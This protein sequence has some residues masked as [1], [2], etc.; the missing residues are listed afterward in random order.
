MTSRLVLVA[1]SP[2]DP[3]ISEVVRQLQRERREVLTC[4]ST[5]TALRAARARH[6]SL[7]VLDAVL[8]DGD[9]LSLCRR[10]KQDPETS[11]IP[12]LCFSSLMARDRCLEAGAD[13]F[14]LKPVERDL[15]LDRIR[16]ILDKVRPI[17]RRPAQPS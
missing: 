2:K 17:R 9:G 13:G 12:V 1:A 3:F 7:V 16:G 10:I 4:H 8:P 14:M 15:L 11:G 5:E 6:P